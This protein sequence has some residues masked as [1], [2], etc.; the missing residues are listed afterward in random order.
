[1]DGNLK[2]SFFENAIGRDLLDLCIKDYESRGSYQTHTMNKAEP[3]ESLS[4]LSELITSLVGQDL[5]YRSGNFYQHSRPY[6][7][8]TD[9]RTDQDNTVNVVIPLYHPELDASLVIFDQEWHENSVSWCMHYPVQEFAVNTGVP[10]W[11]DMYEKVLHKTNSPIDQTLRERFLSRFP[12]KTLH[13]LSGRALPWIPGSMMVFDNRMIHCTSNFTGT[14]LGI[15][16]RFAQ[17]T[18]R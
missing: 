8:H 16:L 18:A 6:L 17:N 2:V 10:G 13:G 15:S 3:G 5:V 11:P 1:M 14:K 7:P 12:E 9:Y 4:V